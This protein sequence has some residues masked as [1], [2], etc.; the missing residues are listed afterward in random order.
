MPSVNR[1]FLL[2]ARPVGMVRREDF[3]YRE[4]PVPDDL[5]AGEARVRNL[6]VSIDPAMRGWMVNR[7]DYVAPLEL[8]DVMRAGCVARVDASR[9]PELREGDLVTGDFG[10]QDYAIAGGRGTPFSPWRADLPATAALS[11]LG[12]TGFTAYFGLMDI[13]RPVAGE[14]VVVSGAAGAVGSIAGQIAK[15]HHCR[16]VGIAG[17]A[18]K[19]PFVVHELGFEAAIDYRA[20]DVAARLAALCPRGIDVYF[21][22][23]GGAVLDAA[24]ARLATHARVVLC[25]AISRSNLTAPTPGPSNYVNLIFRRARM[26]GFIVLDYAARYDEASSALAGW[27]KSGALRYREHVVEGFERLPDALVGLFHG[28]NVGKQIVH[29]GD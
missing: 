3:T 5:A 29:I 1:Q 23:V 14:T 22:N 9:H 6:Y 21:D 20:E 2:A 10:W 25:G 24:L 16:V 4:S 19:C 7:A 28:E 17:G 18:D 8:G 27:A 11:L 12:M 26:E 13:G 15:L